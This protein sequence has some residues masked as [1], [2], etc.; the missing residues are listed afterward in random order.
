MRDNHGGGKGEGDGDGDRKCHAATIPGLGGNRPG[1]RG[2]GFGCTQG[3]NEAA[4]VLAAE[5]AALVR[6]D[7]AVATLKADNA[8]GSDGSIAIIGGASL[9]AGAGVIK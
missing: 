5:A 3:G 9:T 7:E 4:M 6:A 2:W 8:N 1:P